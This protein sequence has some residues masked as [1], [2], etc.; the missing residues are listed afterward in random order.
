LA[1]GSV[2]DTG[3][4]DANYNRHCDPCVNPIEQSPEES[5]VAIIV[6]DDDSGSSA[7]ALLSLSRNRSSKSPKAKISLYDV[8]GVLR[9]DAS[10]P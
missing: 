8:S 1:S 3:Q 6:T 4:R 7:H 9:T 10:W 2:G 5:N